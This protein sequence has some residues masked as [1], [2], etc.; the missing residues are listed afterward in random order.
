MNI[1]PLLALLSFA[2]SYEAQKEE[3]RSALKAE[4]FQGDDYEL[5]RG[6]DS[7]LG[8]RWGRDGRSMT[9]SEAR[10]ARKALEARADDTELRYKLMARREKDCPEHAL[11]LIRARPD[12]RLSALPD[13]YCA[14]KA[15]PEMRKAWEA[16]L[17]ARGSE[18]SVRAHAGDFFRAAQDQDRA[19]AE[20]SAAAAL[21]PKR[22]LWKAHLSAVYR[23]QALKL[24]AGVF[25]REAL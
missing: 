24:D 13:A 23:A 21:E 19:A 9:Q 5:S 12:S 16:V 17:E 11:W 2:S 10:A 18:A 4:G 20:Y 6:A 22:G 8:S 25:E 1:L 15:T 7:L 3:L 14:Y